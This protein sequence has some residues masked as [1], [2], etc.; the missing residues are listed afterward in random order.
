MAV[1]SQ[2]SVAPARRCAYDVLRRVFEHDEFADRALNACAAALD[3]RDRAL[4]MR[5]S[6]G[7]VQRK[8]TLDHFIEALAERDPARLDAPILAALRLGLYELCYLDGAPDRAV[9]AD[10]VEPPKRS[11]RA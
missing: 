9:V 8:R 10:A 1:G 6:Y 2:P 3:R 5:L 4:A 7:A 11:P